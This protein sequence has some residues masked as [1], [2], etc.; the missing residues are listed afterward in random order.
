MR[1]RANSASQEQNWGGWGLALLHSA[2]CL[3]TKK[4][5]RRLCIADRAD[6]GLPAH[7]RNI[8]LF[9]DG[10]ETC[11]IPART[12]SGNNV[13]PSVGHGRRC[14]DWLRGFA[15]FDESR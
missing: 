6:S 1:L 12:L 2:A 7:R 13:S 11:Q 4:F 5:A 15:L 9:R 8:D 3:D 10:W 14:A